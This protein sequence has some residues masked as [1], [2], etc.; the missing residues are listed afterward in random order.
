[1]S[2]VSAL[3]ANPL[4]PICDQPVNTSLAVA[5]W[6]TGPVR[7]V[8]LSDT[9]LR[10]D[11]GRRL[12]DPVYAALRDADVVLH[13]GDVTERG[14]LDELATFAPVHAVL[15]NNDRA[16]R[17]ALPE[18]KVIDLDGVRVGM[19]HDSGPTKGR[20]ARVHRMFPECDV[21]VFGQR[22]I[23]FNRDSPRR[24]TKANDLHKIQRIVI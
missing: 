7:A 22:A 2:P 12:P 18:R 20:P 3:E 24:F 19:V 9:H 15:G 8:V 1:M 6:W 23:E 14:L 10:D 11:R 21:V 16:L 13:C 17:G 4:R 5:V